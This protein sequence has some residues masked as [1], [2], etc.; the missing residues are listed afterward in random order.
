LYC[1]MLLLIPGFYSQ[2]C[3]TA[4]FSTSERSNTF[5]C[6][7]W[8]NE[9]RLLDFIK[10]VDL[11]MLISFCSVYF[12]FGRHGQKS[13]LF[14]S[15]GDIMKISIYKTERTKWLVFQPFEKRITTISYCLK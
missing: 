9:Y 2:S 13:L 3:A 10:R 11:S 6:I 12:N 7:T 5:F 15:S 4:V 14:T 8:W 1:S